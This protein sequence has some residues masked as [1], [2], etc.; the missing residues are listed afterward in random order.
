MQGCEESIDSCG[1]IF[2]FKYRLVSAIN[3]YLAFS[4]QRFGTN[5]PSIDPALY[6]DPENASDLIDSFINCK[7]TG[8]NSCTSTRKAIICEQLT[9]FFNT[10]P[11]GEGILT[12]MNN[13]VSYLNASDSLG[14]VLAQT[15]FPWIDV[16]FSSDIS[17]TLILMK[18]DY[19]FLA[20]SE[21][22]PMFKD[23]KIDSSTINTSS[24]SCICAY[25]CMMAVILV[26]LLVN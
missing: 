11:F 9:G 15:T 1:S 16:I 3:L 2:Q 26:N 17:N 6:Y 12:A 5:I 10:N 19:Q 4:H 18:T 23:I 14:T 22:D 20:T 24:R 7:V 13:L 21:T 25:I 8:Q